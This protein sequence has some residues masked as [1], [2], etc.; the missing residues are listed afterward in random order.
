MDK[1]MSSFFKKMSR[2]ES[3][4]SS[5]LG[6][7]VVAALAV[8]IFMFVKK[9]MP[10]PSLTPLAE[11][12]QSA[13]DLMKQNGSRTYTVKAGQGLSQVAQDALGD[14]SQ[15]KKIAEANDL[16]APYTLKKDQV[17]K[18]PDAE[19]KTAEAKP[20]EAPKA[21][22]VAVTEAEKTSV[23][24]V[25]TLMEKDIELKKAETAAPASE[26]YTVVKGD[27]LWKIA[28]KQY[29]TGYAWVRIYNANKKAIGANPGRIFV[30]TSLV[31]PK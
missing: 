17:L 30:G 1:S 28:E 5:I 23:A 13:E 11:N 16:S 26:S 9:F 7:L 24:K 6:M 19:T 20:A 4:I 8:F 3:E 18:I 2:Y 29:G 22:P 10:K 21:T 25:E 15:W 27:S 14:G 12:T 31:M